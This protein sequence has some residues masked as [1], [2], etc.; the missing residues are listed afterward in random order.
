MA[1]ERNTDLAGCQWGTVTPGES[2]GRGAA[3]V[4]VHPHDIAGEDRRSIEHVFLAV[5]VTSQVVGEPAA[6]SFFAARAA[7]PSRS[8]AA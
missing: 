2:S 4:E 7:S 6:D 5:G 8:V 1:A 3:G